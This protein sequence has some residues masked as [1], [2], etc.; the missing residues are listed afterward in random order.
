MRELYV[1]MPV[2]REHGADASAM[3][4]RRFA[5][6]WVRVDARLMMYSEFL[7]KADG[8]IECVED[9]TKRR[10]PASRPG[11]QDYHTMSFPQ[12]R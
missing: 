5:R 4:G 12:F 7:L 8:T 9:W 1:K 11:R 6:V 3:A 2:W 10:F